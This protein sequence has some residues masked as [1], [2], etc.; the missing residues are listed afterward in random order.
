MIDLSFINGVWLLGAIVIALIL[1][2]GAT[3]RRDG[4]P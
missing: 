4:N 2:L 1:Y 3:N